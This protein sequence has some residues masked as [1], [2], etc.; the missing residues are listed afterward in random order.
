MQEVDQLAPQAVK[1][2]IDAA[3]P[4]RAVHVKDLALDACTEEHDLLQAGLDVGFPKT[5]IHFPLGSGELFRGSENGQ[6]GLEVLWGNGGKGDEHER[7][8]EQ[9]LEAG[10][11]GG[12]PLG[13]NPGLFGQ[14][15]GGGGAVGLAGGAMDA[16]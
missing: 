9:R 15:V 2:A 5:G 4:S 3:D 7:A 10:L 6:D 11:D 13:S 8:G 1:T 12:I 16:G 14:G